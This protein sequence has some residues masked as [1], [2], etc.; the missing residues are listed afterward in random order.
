MQWKGDDGT[1]YI[2]FCGVFSLSSAEDL[3]YLDTQLLISYHWLHY[4]YNVW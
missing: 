2:D 1:I 3:T 4:Y